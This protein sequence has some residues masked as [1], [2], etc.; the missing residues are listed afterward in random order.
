MKLRSYQDY[1]LTLANKFD[2]IKFTHI[3]IYKN[4]FVDALATLTLMTHINIRG[5]IQAINI[6]V[7]NFQAHY[8]ALEETTNEKP[9]YNDIMRL[10]SIKNIL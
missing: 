5:K 8:C 7:K 4:Q 3:I 6:K 2:E 1:L 9:W 10:S